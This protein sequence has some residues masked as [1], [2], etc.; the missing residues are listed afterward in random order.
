MNHAVMISIAAWLLALPALSCAENLKSMHD[1][2]IASIPQ[3]YK[4]RPHSYIKGKPGFYHWH[5]RKAGDNTVAKIRK[6]LGLKKGQYGFTFNQSTKKMCGN[7]VQEVVALF[8]RGKDRIYSYSARC[9][10]WWGGE[11]YTGKLH[12]AL[13]REHRGGYK[14][15]WS[16][17]RHHD[18]AAVI[19]FQ[20]Y[21][22]YM[23]DLDKDGDIE[24][25]LNKVEGVSGEANIYELGK[26]GLKHITVYSPPRGD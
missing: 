17:T 18:H 3:Q 14:K 26:G 2:V 13:V 16:Y 25:K 6:A 10:D 20:W 22:G 21:D 1:Q 8:T 24:V 9:I 4:G 7:K 5:I 19:E 11:G 15:L 23:A 12:A